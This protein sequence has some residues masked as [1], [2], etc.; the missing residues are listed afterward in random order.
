MYRLTTHGITIANTVWVATD[1][2][3]LKCIH[4]D[5]STVPYSRAQN[6][7]YF[8]T[9]LHMSGPSKTAAL[10]YVWYYTK[11]I[12]GLICDWAEEL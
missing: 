2:S 3:N 12:Q 9:I 1:G 5:L 7:L 11:D 8:S 6:Y 4:V 10:S